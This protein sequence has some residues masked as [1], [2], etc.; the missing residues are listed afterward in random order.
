MAR[1]APLDP[2][3]APEVQEAFD[4]IMPPGAPP[5]VLFLTVARS[6]RAWRKFRTASL[7]DRGP[8]SLRDREIVIDRTCA[9]TGCE[10][11]WGVHVTAFAAAARLTPEQ[12]EATV[13]GSSDASCWTA[14][15]QAL[16]AAV[17][18]LHASSRLKPD[19]YARLSGFYAADE[20]LE[21]LMLAGFYR[22]VSYLA[23]GLRP[24]ARAGRGAV[25]QR[26][27]SRP[28]RQPSLAMSSSE[29]SA[30][31]KTFWTSSS[32]SSAS[33]SFISVPASSPATGVSLFGRQTMA[34]ERASPN[35]AARA[36]AT[37]FRSSK[38]V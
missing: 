31:R 26:V 38:A 2:P 30:L 33:T 17:D 11:E 22:T 7:L 3:Y 25:S 13:R 37:P 4:R 8:L 35:L 18:A 14:Q 36:S 29:I 24:A 5:L 21:I 32:S 12:V 10:Y 15:E 16:L 28:P 27:L 1:I 23:N 9:N 34:V 20:I 6:E 19:E